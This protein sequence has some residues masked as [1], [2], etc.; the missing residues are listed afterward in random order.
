M[1]F[2]SSCCLLVLGSITLNAQSV[3]TPETLL[4]LGR[5]NAKGLS[6]DGTRF[7]Y[8]VAIPSM[9]ENKNKST[10]YSIPVDGGRAEEIP[11]FPSGEVISIE[12]AGEHVKVSPDGHHVLFTREVKMQAIFGSDRYPAYPKSNAQIYDQL[13]QRHWDTWE[14][15][16]YS[17]VFLAEVVAGYALHEK[18]LMPGELFDCPQQPFGDDEDVLFTPDGQGV[19]YVCKKKTGTAYA[20]STNTDLYYYNIANGITS[21]LTEA[22]KGYDTNPVFSA[23][24][25]YLAWLS[26]ARDGFEADKSEL[27]VMDWQTKAM[28]S[29]TRDWDETVSSF[30][31]KED[32][33]GLYITAPYHG[34]EQLFEV[35][36]TADEEAANEVRQITKG[37]F[38][39][40]GIAAQQGSVLFVTRT[41]MNHA[42]EVF[43]VNTENGSMQ[44]LT[45]VNDAFYKT[46]Q[47]CSVRSR[48]T[49]LEDGASLFSW[50]IYPPGFDS[51]KKYPVLLYC[52]GGPQS[53]LSQFYSYRWNFQLIASQGYIIIAPNRTGMP[54]WGTHWN[55][56]ISKG[57]GDLPMRDYLAAI[58]DISRESYIDTSRRGAVGA[59]YGGYSVYMLAGIH[60]GRFKTFIAHDGLFDLKSWYGT[61]EELWFANW[62]IGGNYWDGDK[63]AKKSFTQYS[64]SNYIAKWNTPILVFQGGKDY[65]VPIEQGLQAFQAA[66]LKGLKSRFIYMPDEN[67][68]VLKPQTAMV[69]H[70]EFF[71]WLKETL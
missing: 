63:E 66:Q 46:I 34:T 61:T 11:G 8:S 65:R 53:A 2:L 50:V 23:D 68:W 14:D 57:W 4:H 38:D 19:I 51:T 12:P 52:Q 26:M 62:D 42:A 13:D 37:D 44:A 31:W 35:K 39:I 3:L 60:Q 30:R 32:G 18:D 40:T 7:L 47:L 36:R 71:R 17:H 1:R 56:A 6:P 67:H 69:W 49:E 20:Q 29:L 24:G 48:Y 5:V 43:K 21:N 16:S 54:G 9:E 33:S 59:S 70:K 41:D 58:D 10:H 25:H 64:P 22:R 27:W 45:H 15:G 28:H 55:E